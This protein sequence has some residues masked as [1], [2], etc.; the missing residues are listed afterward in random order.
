MRLSGVVMA[1]VLG[2]L[3]LTSAWSQSQDQEPDVQADVITQV[4]AAPSV[5]QVKSAF[6]VRFPGIEVGQ[7]RATP[8][9]GI[10]EVQVGMDLL[11]TDAEVHYIFQ[12]SLIDARE[13]TDLTAT[14]LEQLTAAP[15]A[16][17]PL[18]LAIKQVKGTGARKMAAFEDPNCGFCKRFHETLKE[19]DNITVYTFLLP[20]LS[21]DSEVK[22]RNIWCAKDQEKAWKDW[23]LNNKKPAEAMC[24]TP[25]EQIKELAKK[26]MVQGT[27]AIFFADDSRVNGALPLDQLN[28]KLDAL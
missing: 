1:L 17:L 4:A 20:I 19:V 14:R 28:K 11:Y 15:F 9:Q 3:P 7:V 26:L 2:V 12:G 24:D 23:M 13:R 8:V 6:K 5:D 16:S 21:A 27:P 22:A 25:V 18:E 10:Y